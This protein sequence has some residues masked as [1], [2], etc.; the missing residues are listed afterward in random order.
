MT[1]S[2]NDTVTLMDPVT[3]EPLAPSIKEIDLS[4]ALSPDN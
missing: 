1:N 4:T 2:T 3:E